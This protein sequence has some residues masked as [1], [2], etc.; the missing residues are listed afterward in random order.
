VAEQVQRNPV[1]HDRVARAEAGE[2]PPRR[3]RRP[4]EVLGDDLEVVGAD[5][6]LDQLAVV[7]RPQPDADAVLARRARGAGGRRGGGEHAP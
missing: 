2:V 3:G 7:R 5:L 4:Q 6:D 1:E